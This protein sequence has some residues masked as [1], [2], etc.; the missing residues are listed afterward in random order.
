MKRVLNLIIAKNK[1]IKDQKK[2]IKELKNENKSL[3]A[4]TEKAVAKALKEKVF[5]RE[6]SDSMIEFRSEIKGKLSAQSV[7]NYEILRLA[8]VNQAHD[9]DIKLNL[10]A[11]TE[12]IKKGEKYF[13]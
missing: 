3:K 2:S 1:K 11:L 6:L 12:K 4:E 5:W 10:K 13:N 9:T 7:L 8:G